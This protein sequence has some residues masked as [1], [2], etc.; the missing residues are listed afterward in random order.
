M[1]SSIRVVEADG[2]SLPSL[3]AQSFDVAIVLTVL[4][5]VPDPLSVMRLILNSLNRPGAIMMDFC[6][7]LST[8]KAAV[9]AKDTDK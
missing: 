2:E 7:E 5:H 3:P 4:E 1:Q 9:G 8:A 6:A